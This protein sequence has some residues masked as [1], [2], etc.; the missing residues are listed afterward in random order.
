MSEPSGP[1]L[2]SIRS[3]RV[4]AA[5]QLAKRAL[6]RGRARSSPRARRRSGRRSAAAASSRSC[7]SPPPPAPGTPS[8]PTR[9]P[10][11]GGRPGRQRRG[12]RRA[13]TDRHPAGT[14]RGLPL[15]GRPVRPVLAAARRGWS[16]SWPTSA[17]PATPAPC[18]A[19]PTRRAPTRW[20]SPT[21]RSTS[22]TPRCVR[23]SA[24]SLFHL[25]VAVGV[26]VAEAVAAMRAGP[27]CGFWPPTAGRARPGRDRAGR[28]GAAGRAHRL[29]LRQR[30]V[31]P[32][33][34][35]AGAS[36]T[37]WSRCPSTARPRAS[38]SPPPPPCASTPPPTPAG[39]R[40]SP[41]PGGAGATGA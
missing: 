32:A 27:A 5:R 16:R 23:A 33:R 36:P 12:D 20:S 39:Q 24:G 41:R 21:P 3:P 2:T 25:P 8:S 38:T 11:R 40:G 28:A 26:P 30:G 9:R 4:K 10:G 19:R 13:R 34:R 35:R 6:R 17:T 22:T 37:R 7:S 1:E 31:G 14:G 29:D 15:P 18:C